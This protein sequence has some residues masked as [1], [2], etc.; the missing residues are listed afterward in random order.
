M[1][2]HMLCIT[3]TF[4]KIHLF[5]TS[6]KGKSF[7]DREAEAQRGCVISQMAHSDQEETRI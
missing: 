4:D 7:A 5:L 6:L 2:G 1:F 3:Q